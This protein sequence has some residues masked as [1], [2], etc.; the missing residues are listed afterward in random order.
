MEG[1]RGG[2]GE[3]MVHVSDVE[4]DFVPLKGDQ[5]SYRLCP[6]PPKFERCQAV[7]V[8]ITKMVELPHKRWDTP[9]TPEDLALTEESNH[10]PS[11]GDI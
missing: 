4:S 2:E 6:V 10:H 5:V 7:S 8:Q 9:E 1:C 11:P 3:H